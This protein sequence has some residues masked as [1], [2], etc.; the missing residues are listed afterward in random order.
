MTAW[1]ASL[2]EQRDRLVGMLEAC[3]VVVNA[4]GLAEAPARR[5]SELTTANVAVPLL[6]LAAAEGARC[7]RLVHVSSAAV[8][9]RRDPLD[10][11]TELA[12]FSPYSRSKAAAERELSAVE[13]GTDVVIYRATSVQAPGR[14]IT[15]QLT[16][17][18]SLP[19]VP[20]V[21]R[22]D[23]P[24]P[25]ALLTNVAAAIA[26][27]ATSPIPVGGVYLHPWEHMTVALLLSSLVPGVRLVSV[28]R[29]AV[30]GG[31]GVA[32]RLG[33]RRPRAQAR[34]RRMELMMFG[35]RQDAARLEETG[36]E[37]PV[38]PEGYRE[39]RGFDNAG[40]PSP[41]ER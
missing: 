38:G 6:L 10:E 33:A 4:A 36:F 15:Q 1:L 28:P 39:L 8:Q 37:C 17:Y 5:S 18:A 11:S 41:P 22:G 14:S 40:S 32:Q 29:S 2:P 3:D 30:R 19:A 27:L 35:Q 21:E 20:V 16:R 31:L 34:L 13:T 12:P 7:P 24:V 23:V 26:H 25:V 9:G